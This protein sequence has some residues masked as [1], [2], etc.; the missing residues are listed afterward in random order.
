[1][2]RLNY[3][4]A[5]RSKREKACIFVL[6]IFKGAKTVNKCHFFCRAATILTSLI[7]N[8]P[9]RLFPDSTENGCKVSSIRRLFYW[10]SKIVKGLRDARRTRP[11][12]RWRYLSFHQLFI[13]CTRKSNS[14]RIFKHSLRLLDNNFSGFSYYPIKHTF[15]KACLRNTPLLFN[16]IGKSY[17]NTTITITLILLHAREYVCIGFV[18]TI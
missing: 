10:H 9:G 4:G 12:N 14:A 16:P 13:S 6:C 17:P 18:Y 2:L 8:S 3:G 11:T 7:K 5:L 1:M 15:A